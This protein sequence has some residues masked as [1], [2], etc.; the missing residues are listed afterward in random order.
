MRI[1][2]QRHYATEWGGRNKSGLLPS[3]AA[4]GFKG[5]SNL[6]AQLL[7]DPAAFLHI[8]MAFF[9]LNNKENSPGLLI[10]QKKKGCLS[11]DEND[12]L[13]RGSIVQFHAS[14]KHSYVIWQIKRLK[15]LLEFARTGTMLEILPD[16]LLDKFFTLVKSNPKVVAA[17]R[18][19]WSDKI[20]NR[21][22]N[23]TYRYKSVLECGRPQEQFVCQVGY[24]R[25]DFMLMVQK[26]YAILHANSILFKKGHYYTRF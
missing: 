25:P 12:L 26:D 24:L 2:I 3:S 4:A 23:T 14:R 13:E 19:H 9:A 20:T 15:G 22:K 16:N 1:N 10:L 5:L 18:K 11:R 8:L 6:A 17:V 21:Q 7:W